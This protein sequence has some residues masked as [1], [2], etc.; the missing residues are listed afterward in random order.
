MA[1]LEVSAIAVIDGSYGFIPFYH[2]IFFLIK[3]INPVIF[4]IFGEAVVTSIANNVTN[5]TL[6]NTTFT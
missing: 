2:G 5:S 4:N 3:N 6:L 1:I